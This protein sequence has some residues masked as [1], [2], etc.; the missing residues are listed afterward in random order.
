MIL[1]MLSWLPF[2][3]HGYG[4]TRQKTMGLLR[5]RANLFLPQ[6]ISN[7]GQGQEFFILLDLLRSYLKFKP[8]TFRVSIKNTNKISYYLI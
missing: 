7:S 4:L 8:W 3:D 2:M 1:V 5:L 6:S